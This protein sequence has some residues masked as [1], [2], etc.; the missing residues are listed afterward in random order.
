M[1]EQ[2]TDK[3]RALWCEAVHDSPMWPIHG[4]YQCRTCGRR[5]PVEWAAEPARPR[6][7]PTLVSSPARRRPSP[8]GLS[9]FAS[10]LVGVG[11]GVLVLAVAALV[12]A[13]R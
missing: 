3:L 11:L 1:L 7:S 12:Y 13:L 8:K 5:Y 10:L 6:V 9:R 2:A 4:Q